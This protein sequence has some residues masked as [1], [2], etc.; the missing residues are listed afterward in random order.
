MI[1]RARHIAKRHAVPAGVESGLISDTYATGLAPEYTGGYHAARFKSHHQVGRVL[2]FMG[3][4]HV[5]QEATESA[6]K[7]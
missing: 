2:D 1:V 6:E 5:F 4:I 7:Q 3:Y